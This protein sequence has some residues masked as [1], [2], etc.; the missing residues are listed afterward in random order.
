MTCRRGRR[1]ATAKTAKRI[2]STGTELPSAIRRIRRRRVSGTSSSSSGLHS[3]VRRGVRLTGTGASVRRARAR[4]VHQRRRAVRRAHVRTSRHANHSTFHALVSTRRD[5]P[6]FVDDRERANSSDVRR[7]RI[8]ANVTVADWMYGGHHEQRFVSVHDLHRHHAKR[9]WRALTDPTKTKKWWHVSFVTDWKVGSTMDVK[10]G[11][12][13]IRDPEQV[14]LESTSP[15][16]LAYTWHTFTP[17]WA[18]ANGY[19]RRGSTEVRQRD[20]LQGDL[21]HRQGPTAWSG[22]PSLHDGFEPDSVV[23]EAIREGWPPFSRA[24]RR[25]SRPASRSTSSM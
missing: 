9:L 5:R 1:A 24:S 25:F 12:L 16:R 17:A 6:A 20:A 23:L 7:T 21:R 8:A 4:D 3:G 14:V 19:S 15:S 10:M 11:H 13:T 2:V 18:S 22:S